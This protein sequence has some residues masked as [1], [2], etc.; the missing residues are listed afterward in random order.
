MCPRKER[1]CSSLLRRGWVHQAGP[2]DCWARAYLALDNSGWFPCTQPVL[3]SVLESHSHY[4]CSQGFCSAA[5][6]PLPPSLILSLSPPFLLCF[7]T[8]IEVL[9]PCA[10]GHVPSVS[11][12]AVA[13]A[14]TDEFLLAF[15]LGITCLLPFAFSLRQRQFKKLTVVLCAHL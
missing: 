3:T 4:F 9:C 11:H 10:E 5:T 7:G 14:Q 13:P 2:L 15:M 1:T 8:F 12:R 6:P